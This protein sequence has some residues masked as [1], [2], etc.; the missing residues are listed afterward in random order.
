MSNPTTQYL[1]HTSPTTIF[2]LSVIFA[3]IG[4]ST[5]GPPTGMYFYNTNTAQLADINTIFMSLTSPSQLKLTYL[6]NFKAPL[7]S[8]LQDLNE[9]FVAAPPF[10]VTPFNAYTY[11]FNPTYGYYL[12]VFADYLSNTPMSDSSNIGYN[13]FSSTLTFTRDVTSLFVTIIG[14]GGG[15]G[16]GNGYWACGGG[17]GAGGGAANF[18]LS[19]VLAGTFFP[20]TVGQGGAGGAGS[21]STAYG[22]PGAN[23]SS[24]GFGST[25]ASGGQ[26]GYGGLLYPGGEGGIGSYGGGSGGQGEAYYFTPNDSVS[27]GNGSY[28][29]IYPGEPYYYY[30]GGGG[31]GGTGG[32]HTTAAGGFGGGGGGGTQQSTGNDGLSFTGPNGI[33]YAQGYNSKTSPDGYGGYGW[34]A[35]GGGGNG[36][37]APGAGGGGAVPNGCRG[38]SGIVI[39]YF[40]HS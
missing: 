15:G 14:G 33:Y 7:Y 26:H 22:K 18:S 2:D 4:T 17:G 38:G 5:L 27:G 9:F 12:V 40:K 25:S 37:P 13:S 21:N 29:Y 3:P 8:I 10:Y 31:A 11:T 30:L 6:T 23:G 19:S 35:T 36:G 24:S 28:Y 16:G 1:V 39:A 34:P 32:D 20:V